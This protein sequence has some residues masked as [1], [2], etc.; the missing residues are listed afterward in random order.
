MTVK[1]N[2]FER[3]AMRAAEKSTARIGLA[4][5]NQASDIFRLN[6]S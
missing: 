1:R 2:K 4:A 5:V 3:S 6:L